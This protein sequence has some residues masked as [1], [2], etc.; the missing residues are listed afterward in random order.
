VSVPLAL[1]LP[2]AEITPI[3]AGSGILLA[4]WALATGLAGAPRPAAVPAAPSLV[5]V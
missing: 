5:T 2:D 3:F 1:A 4:L